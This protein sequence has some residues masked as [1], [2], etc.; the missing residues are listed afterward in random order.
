G[1]LELVDGQVRPRFPEVHQTGREMA[2]RVGLGGGPPREGQD[3]AEEEQGRR[4]RS[5]EEWLHAL[6]PQLVGRD[7]VPA[8][9]GTAGA[10]AAAGWRAAAEARR[11]LAGV[12]SP[13]AAA[14]SKAST[15]CRSNFFPARKR[16]R[17]R[18]AS[19]VM[20]LE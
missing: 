6:G 11:A 20:A 12:S 19:K 10:G 3:E 18:A 15:H 9:A 5:R 14:R 1:L 8:G 16:R 7:G 2:L 17:A 4:E 13:A